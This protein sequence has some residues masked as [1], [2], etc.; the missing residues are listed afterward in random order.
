V[1]IIRETKAVKNTVID[2]VESI[3]QVDEDAWTVLYFIDGGYDIV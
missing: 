3:D 1:A 2:R